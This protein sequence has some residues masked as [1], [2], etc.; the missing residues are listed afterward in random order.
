MA[1]DFGVIHLPP[2]TPAR[3]TGDSKENPYAKEARRKKRR[4]KGDP[5]FSPEQEQEKDSGPEP[6]D[7]IPSGKVLDILI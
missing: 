2:L 4:K 6:K 1:D 5:G 7:E 3:N